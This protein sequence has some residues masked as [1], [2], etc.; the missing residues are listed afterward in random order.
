[1]SSCSCPPFCAD[2]DRRVCRHRSTLTSMCSNVHHYIYTSTLTPTLQLA[3]TFTHA[4]AH[5]HARHSRCFVFHFHFH[6]H[7]ASYRVL[8]HAIN[9]STAIRR[10]PAY[11]HRR[12]CVL[13][14]LYEA[15]LWTSYNNILFHIE[16]SIRLRCYNVLGF[17]FKEC[18]FTCGVC[19]YM[20]RIRSVEKSRIKKCLLSMEK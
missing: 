8:I 20:R 5:M 4:H 1:M 13:L 17:Y 9:F 10:Y 19:F 7:D 15:W 3:H 6:L 16:Y 14:L 2:I 12:L 11:N 18:V